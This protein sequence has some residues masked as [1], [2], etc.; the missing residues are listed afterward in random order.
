MASSRITAAIALI[1]AS[2]LVTGPV[3]AQDAAARSVTFADWKADAPGAVHRITP[4]DLPAP[5]MRE[6]VGNAPDIVRQPISAALAVPAGFS[7]ARFATGLTNPRIIR[8]APNGD[9]FIAESAAGR[10]RVMRAA[11]GAARPERVEV[12]AGGL[13]RPFGIA[14]QPPGPNPQ[15]LYVANNNTV[16]RFAYRSGDLSARGPAQTVV[17]Q[18]SPTSGHHWTRDLAFSPDGRQMYVSVGS[19]S[20]DAAGMGRLAPAAIA[21]NEARH[22]VGAAWG[23]EMLRAAV[24]VFDPA[25][26]SRRVFA[27]GL[28]NCAGLAVRQS[29]GE[30]W[31]STN[32]RDGLGNNLPPDYV[33]R[34]R[35]GA[36]YG[37]PWF[38]I[39]AHEDPRHRGT[40][41]DLA[42]RVS[43]P[44][45]LVQPHSAP[46]GMVFYRGSGVA[47]FP[48]TYQGDAFVAL[49]GSW[50]RGA[51]TGYK[52]IRIHLGDGAPDG[53]YQDFLTGFVANDASVWGRPVGVAVARDGA[54]LITDDA[55][56]TIW[57]V[58]YANPAAK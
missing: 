2:L 47:A 14:F 56:G 58:A 48:A 57:R 34:V 54:L 3:A 51:R 24:L 8:V 37:W 43:V 39:G 36:F 1:A 27:T 45:V 41:P 55:S 19:G 35:P 26:G 29:S 52:V 17:A 40:R 46:L 28:R 4:A 42:D 53:S 44:D 16:V 25:G 15:W 10:I 5:S 18:I 38:Y 11:D 20:N 50:N 30:L 6:S 7:V 22:G 23:N 49:H 32:E 13:D 9:I 33:T 21:A 31:C 12:F